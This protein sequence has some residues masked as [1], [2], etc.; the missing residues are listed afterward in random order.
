MK[1]YNFNNLFPNTH[2]PKMWESSSTF[3]LNVIKIQLS[4]EFLFSNTLQI[5]GQEFSYMQDKLADY[6]LT[7]FFFLFF[8]QA[9]KFVVGVVG[10]VERLMVFSSREFYL[11]DLQIKMVTFFQSQMSN[12]VLV[13]C[14]YYVYLSVWAIHF[15]V[16]FNI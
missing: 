6:V 8:L 3:I 14:R 1:T 13:Y 15:I 11:E 9:L 5:L 16:T 4:Y 10:M 12:Q 2:T 7:N